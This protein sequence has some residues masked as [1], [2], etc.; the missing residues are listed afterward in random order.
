MVLTSVPG[1]EVRTATKILTEVIGKSFKAT[2]R[3]APYAGVAP[4]TR[5]LGTS[6]RGEFANCRG[7]KR[8]KSP[9]S[10]Q[11]SHPFIVCLHGRATTKKRAADKSHK[12][13]I[14]A[15]ARDRTLST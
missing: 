11:F 2:G 14:I 7:S 10:T 9:Y 3:L 15:L 1:L 6:I 12:Q 5:H 4:A 13:A 8:L